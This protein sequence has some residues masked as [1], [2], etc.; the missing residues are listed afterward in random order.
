MRPKESH[1]MLK[2]V[3]SVEKGSTVVCEE[4]RKRASQADFRYSLARGSFGARLWSG[5]AKPRDGLSRWSLSGIV[6]VIMD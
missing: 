5:H 4:K 2:A 1:I 3:R 6:A